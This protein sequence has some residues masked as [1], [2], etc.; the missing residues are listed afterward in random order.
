[1]PLVPDPTSAEPQSPKKF[2]MPF[3]EESASS[4]EY[5]PKT[6]KSA[7]RKPTK[8]RRPTQEERDYEMM[9]DM[10]KRPWTGE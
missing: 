4:T 6:A 10:Y 9:D 3:R 1:M 5:V 7:K 2:N 8:S